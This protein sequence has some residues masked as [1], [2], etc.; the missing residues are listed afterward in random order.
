MI[1]EYGDMWTV[2]EETDLFLFTANSMLT[3]DGKLVMGA[4]IA[5]EVRDKFPGIDKRLGEYLQQL[6]LSGK[7]FNLLLSPTGKKVG[8]FQTKVEW[9]HPSDLKLIERSVA[10]LRSKAGSFSR[11]DLAFPGINNG[12]LEFD[13]VYPIVQQLPDNVYLWQKQP[14]GEQS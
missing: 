3:K 13:K 2:W 12:K 10:V 5:K 1:L 14:T 4:G 8:A 6:N 9:K 7:E 11:I